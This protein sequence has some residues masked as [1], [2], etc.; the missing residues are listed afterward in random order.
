VCNVSRRDVQIAQ[1]TESGM[2]VRIVFLVYTPEEITTAGVRSGGRKPVE[3]G[4]GV[5]TKN[6][7]VFS[8]GSLAIAR[9]GGV[10][11]FSGAC[12]CLLP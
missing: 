5:G 2:F 8:H 7:S 6:R 3:E 12:V 9:P 10:Q 11:C 4:R 1:R